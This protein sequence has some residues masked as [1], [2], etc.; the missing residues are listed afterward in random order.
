MSSK[1][2]NTTSG[3]AIGTMIPRSSSQP[4]V[5]PHRRG[6]LPTQNSCRHVGS[7]AAPQGCELA[8]HASQ[9]ILV[10]TIH[11]SPRARARSSFQTLPALDE[12]HPHFDFQNSP[13]QSRRPH[14]QCVTRPCLPSS[15]H[16]NVGLTKNLMHRTST[17][18]SPILK[19]SKTLKYLFVFDNLRKSH[20]CVV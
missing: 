20:R 13:P 7:P 12:I 5:V 2:G 9:P 14:G 11:G 6:S 19:V 18:T 16:R 4:M 3:A 17:P 8:R 1:S 10:P 15:Q